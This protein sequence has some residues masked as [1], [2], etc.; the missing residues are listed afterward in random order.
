MTNED[1]SLTLQIAG[2]LVVIAFS[3]TTRKLKLSLF[4]AA[5]VMIIVTIIAEFKII[6]GGPGACMNIFALPIVGCVFAWCSIA[7]WNYFA[8]KK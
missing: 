6:G 3:L 7:I 2:L 1:L 5:F 4:F 8:A